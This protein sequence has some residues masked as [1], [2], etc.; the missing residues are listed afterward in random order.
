M[1][2]SIHHFRSAAFV[3]QNGLCYYCNLPMWLSDPVSFSSRLAVT[4]T[5]ARI[6][7]CTAEHLL[8]RSE[9]GQDCASNIVAACLYCNTRRHRRKKTVR[10]PQ[11]HRKHVRNRMSIRRWHGFKIPFGSV[12]V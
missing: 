7:Q 6:L 1:S 3:R 11:D 5:Q 2:K 8:P 4:Q 12:S 10:S 9:G